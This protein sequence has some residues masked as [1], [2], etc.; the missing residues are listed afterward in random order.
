MAHGDGESVGKTARHI[1]PYRIWRRLGGTQEPH[2]GT[3]PA[4]LVRGTTPK[5]RKI[6]IHALSRVGQM[7]RE[8]PRLGMD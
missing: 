6:V 7:E 8:R 2:A 3:H 1:G 4:L 5:K